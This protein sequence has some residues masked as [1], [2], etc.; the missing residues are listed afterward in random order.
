MGRL[1]IAPGFMA[2]KWCQKPS[3]LEPDTSV[4]RV[5]NIFLRSFSMEML[6]ILA[7]SLGFLLEAIG[8]LI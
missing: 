3:C 7:L 5:E 8:N 2:S 4:R 6:N 1:F